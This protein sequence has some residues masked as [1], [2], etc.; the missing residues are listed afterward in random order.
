MTAP[1][2]LAQPTRVLVLAK[3]PQP[4]RVKTRLIPLLGAA[5]AALLARQ[6]L[7]QTLQTALDAALGPV[8]L[9]M[10]PAPGAAAW[11]GVA[12]PVGV[13]CSAQGKGDLGQRMARAVTSVTRR[14]RD[15]VLLIGTDCPVLTAQHLQQAAQALWHHDAVMLGAHDGGYVLLGLK[16]PCAAIFADMPWSTPAVAT[17]TLQRLAE[18]GLRVWQGPVLHDIDEPAD[19]LHLPQHLFNPR[20]S[21]L[22]A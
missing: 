21:V 16:A 7:A 19:L 18:L 6:M 3:A 8:E 5:G 1:A 2:T 4:G 14:H 15:A 9:C 12:I 22:V 13:L 17:Q 11:E 10:S 20:Q